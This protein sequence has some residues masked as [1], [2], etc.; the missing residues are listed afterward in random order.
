MFAKLLVIA[1]PDRGKYFEVVQ[2]LPLVL[3]RNR[4]ADARLT[5]PRVSPLH[6]QVTVRNGELF[7]TDLDSLAGT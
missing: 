2:A 5:D 3:G 1:G 7:V 4:E 6:C